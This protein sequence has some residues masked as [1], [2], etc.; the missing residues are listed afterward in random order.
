MTDNEPIFLRHLVAITTALIQTGNYTHEPGDEC[1]GLNQTAEG[2]PAV[3]AA[4]N[5][6]LFDLIM[7]AEHL[8]NFDRE[9]PYT[10]TKN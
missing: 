9:K 2:E 8:A 3:T 1:I 10:E 6:I 5:E 7:H 4:A